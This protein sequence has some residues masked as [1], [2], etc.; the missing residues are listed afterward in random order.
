MTYHTPVLV[1]EVLHYLE[2]ERGGWYF[3]GTVGGGG[4][5]EAILERG[6]AVRLIGADRD[7]EA[8]AVAGE[9]L[10][11]FGSRV[12]LVEAS[13]AEAAA[14]VAEPLTGALLDLGVSSHQID[15]AERGFSF[16]PG[17]P[18]DM[19][20]APGAAGRTAADLLN[21]LSEER[22]S[23]IFRVYGEEPRARRLARTVV[24]RRRTSAFAT[25]DDL[26]A[27]VR[28]ALGPRSGPQDFAR[29]FQALRIVV[30]DELEQL[31]GA[32]EELREK[33]IAGGVLVILAYHSLEDRRVKNAFREWSRACVCP[34]ELPVCRCRGVPLGEVLTRKPVSASAAEVA[35]N[36][37]ARSA[38]LRAWRKAA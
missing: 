23:E 26:V 1:Q 11:R 29:I 8:L 14:R 28:R 37:R 9:R 30:N 32:L 21:E 36:A 15:E 3:D 16:R 34:P 38:R 2:P 4:H 31:E 7:P 33:L 19:R 6:S 22:L 5:A 10:A 25:S 24:E 20:M 18:L 12:R 17:V 35:A 13:F 27:A